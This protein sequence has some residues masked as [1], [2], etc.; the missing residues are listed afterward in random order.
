MK[1]YN[2]PELIKEKR[3]SLNETGTEFGKRFGV[4]QA[5]VSDWENGKSE[6]GYEVINFVLGAT[7]IKPV[8]ECECY[9]PSE[10]VK[11]TVGC[12]MHGTPTI[13]PL[14]F[15]EIEPPRKLFIESTT[16]EDVID[17]RELICDLRMQNI[18]L[19]KLIKLALSNRK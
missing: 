3:Q 18:Q 16:L 8:D 17:N 7:Q 10:G 6:A 13:E 14:E 1:K 9:S 15:E 19:I 5:A 12:P 11:I 2:F 4:S